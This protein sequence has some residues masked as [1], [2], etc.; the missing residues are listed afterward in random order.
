MEK[1]VG[2]NITNLL[3]KKLFVQMENVN[4]D[5]HRYASIEILANT[6]AKKYVHI[7][8]SVQ[9]QEQSEDNWKG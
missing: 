7:S 6:L 1:S 5:I 4:L 2:T 3:V 8:K 9:K